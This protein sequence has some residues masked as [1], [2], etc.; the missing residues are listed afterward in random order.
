MLHVLNSD[1]DCSSNSLFKD[2]N[3][4]PPCVLVIEAIVLVSLFSF[5][6]A[7]SYLTRYDQSAMLVC[8][9][10]IADSIDSKL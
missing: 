3:A 7:F 5:A 10:T 1:F 6:F 9:F 4:L 8:G 2:N